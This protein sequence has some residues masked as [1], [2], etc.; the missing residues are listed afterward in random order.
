MTEFKDSNIDDKVVCELAKYVG[1]E[2][3]VEYINQDIDKHRK[4]VLMFP[5]NKRSF[6][7]GK[8]DHYSIV[9]WNLSDN[10]KLNAVKSIKDSYGK[11][12]YMNDT[13]Y[14]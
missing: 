9:Y 1:K 2:I 7:I 3:H 4:A 5:P 12:I 13:F 8:D 10:G 11:Q 14:D 6:H